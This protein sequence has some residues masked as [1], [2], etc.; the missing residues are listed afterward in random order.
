[1]ETSSMGLSSEWAAEHVTTIL[2]YVPLSKRNASLHFLNFVIANKRIQLSLSTNLPV[3][4]D[5]TL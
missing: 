2:Y 4:G 3:T 5:L 1:M